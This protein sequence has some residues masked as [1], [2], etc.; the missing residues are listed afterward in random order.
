[1]TPTPSPAHHLSRFVFLL[2]AAAGCASV[3]TGVEK[4]VK[5]ADVEVLKAVGA[6]AGGLVVWTSSREGLPHIFVMKTDGTDVRPLTKGSHTD[7]YPRV[8]P[9]GGKVL[10]T[11]SRAKG[12]VRE[13]DAATPETWD[14]YTVKI[15]GTEPTKVVEDARWGSW[16][17][18]D[19]IVF[20]R[21]ASV[22]R[23]KLG[24]GEETELVDT[25]AQ[26]VFGGAIVQQPQL[27][28]DGKYLALTLAGSRRQVGIWKIK[29]KL[30]T[31]VGMGQQIAWAPDGASVLWV[32]P[33]GMGLAQL[34]R[35]PIEKGL[36]AKDLDKA[37]LPLLDVPGKRTREAFPRLSSDGKWLV[38]A[39]AVKGAESD[40]ED[41]ELYLWEVGS[42][43]ESSARLTFHTGTDS[44]PDLFVSGGGGTAPA[45]GEAPEGAKA[46]V[47]KAAPANEGAE[48]EKA[49]KAEPAE[50]S[51]APTEEAPAAADEAV[52]D[53]ETA[54][55]K[56][57]GKGKAQ[58]KAKKK[59]R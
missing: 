33:T 26:A 52:T 50:T 37:T 18:P 21:G 17:G 29:K 53:E 39:G 6:K 54:P 57:K 20:M 24:G 34:Y 19:E 16:A 23:A 11:R 4:D 15:D 49:S 12:F 28:P 56:A 3:T 27:S 41:F 59:R 10:F 35:M 47:P 1:M 55:L 58:P 13:R 30:W 51:G 44:W 5:P 9:D 48:T 14:L 2:A 45:E 38:F 25:S 36:P 7:W 31:Q 40:L 43:I 32:N 46:D 42:P 8:S 22:L